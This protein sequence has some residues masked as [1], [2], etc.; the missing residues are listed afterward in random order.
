MSMRPWRKR[1]DKDFAEEIQMHIVQET[2]RLIEE[3]GLPRRAGHS[4]VTTIVRQCRASTG[5]LL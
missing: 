2:K 4:Q 1:S 3:E 5:T